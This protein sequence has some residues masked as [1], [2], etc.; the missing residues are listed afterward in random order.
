MVFSSSVK[1]K[2]LLKSFWITT[3]SPFTTQQDFIITKEKNMDDS[4]DGFFGRKEN[5]NV[6]SEFMFKST[7][8]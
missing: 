2:K 7:A 8:T 4:L 3:G 5:V 1:K 6:F